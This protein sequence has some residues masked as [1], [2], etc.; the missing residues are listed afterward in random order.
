MAQ[1]LLLDDG[2]PGEDGPPLPPPHVEQVGQHCV[3]VRLGHVQRELCA[4][5]GELD[6]RARDR[7][8]RRALLRLDAPAARITSY[9]VC[10]TKLLRTLELVP[11]DDEIHTIVRD[12]GIG[13]RERDLQR[14]FTAFSQLEDAKTRRREGTGLGLTITRELVE[15]LGGRID[16]SS[17]FG[18]GTT[19]RVV[20]PL[21]ISPSQWKETA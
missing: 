4:L 16:V 2:A 10:Y 5:R 11:G 6:V 9:N 17:T 14:L 18:A 3:E 8:A 1:Q 12:T 19:F 7:G 13:I 20:F 15:R 21:N